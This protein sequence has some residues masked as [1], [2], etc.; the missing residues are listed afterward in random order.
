MKVGIPLLD[1]LMDAH[2]DVLG[3]ERWKPHRS[4]VHAAF[5]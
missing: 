1:D 4:V 2:R 3:S 5:S